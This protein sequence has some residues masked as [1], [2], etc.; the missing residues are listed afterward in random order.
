MFD[1]C[2][3][4]CAHCYEIVNIEFLMEIISCAAATYTFDQGLK[5]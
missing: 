4:L 1:K 5:G 2:F 3:K